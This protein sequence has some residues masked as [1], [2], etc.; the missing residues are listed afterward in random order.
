MPI[1]KNIIRCQN[2]INFGFADSLK[3]RI[4]FFGKTSDSSVGKFIKVRGFPEILSSLSGVVRGL[5]EEVRGLSDEVRGLSEEV[6]GL[7]EEVR[8]LSDGVRSLFGGVRSLYI[9]FRNLSEGRVN[10]S[11]YYGGFP[12][13]SKGSAP[14]RVKSI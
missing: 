6:R 12:L 11:G 4:K 14:K 13:C 9:I 1:I 2:K 8:G 5:S 3:E 10:T 7:S